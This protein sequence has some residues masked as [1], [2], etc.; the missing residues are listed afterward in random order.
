MIHLFV[1][2]VGFIIFVHGKVVGRVWCRYNLI[3]GNFE[4]CWFCFVLIDLL[5][6]I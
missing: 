1:G 3:H 6:R 2:F 4:V 5:E